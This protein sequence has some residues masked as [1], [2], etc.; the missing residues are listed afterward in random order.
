MW[1]HWCVEGIE[2]QSLKKVPLMFWRVTYVPSQS[3][4]HRRSVVVGGLW[5]CCPS[6]LLPFSLGSKLG[7]WKQEVGPT[8]WLKNTAAKIRLV[9]TH[10]HMWSP[11]P[12]SS[13]PWRG[14]PSTQACRETGSRRE[15]ARALPLRLSTWTR[16]TQLHNSN[17]MVRPL[18]RSHLSSKI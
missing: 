11:A 17:K 15:Q 4:Q 16:R 10:T 7:Q 5:R 2:A 14:H 1:K 18:G 8:V 9:H 6:T 13:G 12:V 3:R